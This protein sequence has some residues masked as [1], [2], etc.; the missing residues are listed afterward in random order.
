MSYEPPPQRP[1]FN[2]PPDPGYAAPDYYQRQAGQPWAQQP[3]AQQQPPYYPPQQQYYPAQQSPKKK[4]HWVRNTF[5]GLAGFIV[6]IVIISVATNGGSNGTPAAGSGA[7]PA[8]AAPA[9]PQVAKIGTPVRDGKFQFT[10]TS[11]SH[12]KSVGDTADGFGDTAQGKYTIL[13]VTV[14]NI[15][16]QPQTLFD[17]NQYVFDASGR[18]Y[19]VSTSADMDINGA[20]RQRTFQRHQPG[21]YG[22]RGAGIRHACGAESGEG[23]TARL[24]VLWWCHR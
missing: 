22:T 3:H 5:L 12:A 13:H 6:L 16:S 17:S 24:S 23:R 19:D 20:S 9:A 18:K 8:N 10:I 2:P 1:S 15:S 7:A 21:Q 11:V 14:T 4:R